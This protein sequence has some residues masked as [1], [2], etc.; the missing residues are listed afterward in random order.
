[1]AFV[2][3]ST[4]LDDICCC[5]SSSGFENNV[6]ISIALNNQYWLSNA[7]SFF[8]MKIELTFF[9]DDAPMM[10]LMMFCPPFCS[11]TGCVFLPF[12]LSFVCLLAEISF[13]CALKAF[14]VAFIPFICVL[15][16]TVRV[17]YTLLHSHK[18]FAYY[19]VQIQSNVS[20]L[21]IFV[22]FYWWISVH[23]EQQNVLSQNQIQLKIYI[24]LPLLLL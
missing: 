13:A 10:M 18:Y 4:S 19:T 9:I 14:I 20:V 24:L 12:F 15:M 6:S 3:S 23:I 21:C 7:K 5:V 16:R 11:S 22:S 2:S 8:I 17:Q 1:M